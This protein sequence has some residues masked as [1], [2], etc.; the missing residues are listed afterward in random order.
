VLPPRQSAPLAL[1]WSCALAT[2]QAAPTAQRGWRAAW[3]LVR[4]REKRAGSRRQPRP[5]RLREL[6]A[7]GDRRSTRGRS[8]M[9]SSRWSPAARHPLARSL[10]SDDSLTGALPAGAAAALVLHRRR[11]DTGHHM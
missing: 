5:Q 1:F 4:A 6:A 11:P 3:L 7:I 9:A 2:V 10:L 8:A